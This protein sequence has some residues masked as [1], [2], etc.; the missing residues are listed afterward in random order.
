MTMLIFLAKFFHRIAAHLD[1]LGQVESE[2]ERQA[3]IDHFEID[4]MR[5]AAIRR[6]LEKT[7]GAQ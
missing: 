4:A 3:E 1:R 7:W 6:N 2:C 5:R